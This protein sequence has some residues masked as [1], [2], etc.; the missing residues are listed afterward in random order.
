MSI[1]D[2]LTNL[3]ELS[4]TL[5]FE[6]VP[7]GKT[8]K[9][10][11]ANQVLVKDER[12]SRA[13]QDIKPILDQLHEEFI[14]GS[15]ANINIDWSGYLGI[16]QAV[17][18]EQDGEKKEVLR[19]KKIVIE[20][21][22]R[23][24]IVESYEEE[25]NKWKSEH[26][27]EK[28]KGLL[29]D[30]SYEVLTEEGILKVLAQKHKNDKKTIG[31]ISEFEGF[32]TY[33]SGFNNNRE[34][35]YSS[36]EK[37]T[38]IAN[39]IVN[40]NL[41][42]FCANVLSYKK[43]LLSNSSVKADKN[44]FELSHYNKVLTQ[45]DIEAYNY[46]IGEIN[47]RINLH[48]QSQQ[49]DKKIPLL[50]TLYKQIGCAAMK[51]FIIL[52]IDDKE[53][54]LE[55]AL[56]EYIK[57]ADNSNEKII[58]LINTLGNGTDINQVYLSS[59][60]IHA[61]SGKFFT[62]AGW[63]TLKNYL[64]DNKIYKRDK[65]GEAAIASYTKLSDL[66]KAI[67]AINEF[68]KNLFRDSF[69]LHFAS[70]TGFDIFLNILKD[71]YIKIY[72]IKQSKYFQSLGNDKHLNT[73]HWYLK[74][75]E[76]VLKLISRGLNKR[77][78]KQK[79]TIK[80]MA[81]DALTLFRMIKYFTVKE[82]R[83]DLIDTTFYEKLKEI[84]QNSLL[85]KY[86]DAIR[87][88]LTR[89]PYNRD[90]I[91]LN[92]ACST[93]LGGWDKNKETSNLSYILRDDSGKYFLAVANKNHNFCFDRQK[94]CYLYDISTNQ[95]V[96]Q[97]MEYKLLPGPNKMLPKV[98]FAKSNIKSPTNLKGYFDIPDAILRIREKESFKKGDTFSKTD[99]IKWIDFCKE[100]I[101]KYPDWQIFGFKFLPSNAYDDVSKFYNHIQKQ[102]Y[103]L[104]F[105]SINKAVI[106][107]MVEEGQIF[108]FQ[109]KNKDFNKK[110]E[111]NKPNLHTLY[112][113]NLFA[114]RS[115]L[116]KL[117]GEAELFYR[118]KSLE[119]TGEK[120][121][122]K[123]TCHE[124]IN[125][126]RYTKDKFLFH[127][128]IT[129][130]FCLRGGY[131][132]NRVREI[133]TKNSDVRMIG[134]DRGE[135]HLAYYSIINL[136]GNIIEQGTLNKDFLGQNYAEKL[137]KRAGDRDEARKNWQRIE[138]IKELKEGYIS[139]VV[140]R[141]A[142]LALEHNAIIILEDLNFR[143]MRGRQ[144]IEK[145]VYQKLELAL[146]KKLNYFVLK[147][148]KD[149]E[150][151]SVTKAYQL[152]PPTQNFGD[153]KGKQWGIMFYTRAAY[154]SI[155]DPV[156]GFRQNIYLKKGCR[157][158]MRS[159]IL[160]FKDIGFDNNKKA[161]YFRYNP[162]DFKD[163]KST[164]KEWTVW[165]NVERIINKKD[166]T[167]NHW[168]SENIDVN[169]NLQKIFSN[170]DHK[171]PLIEQ[172]RR[173]EDLPN[174]FYED[175][176]W[177]INRILQLRNSDSTNDDDYIQSP[178]EPFFDSREHKPKGQN[179]DGTDKANM[180]TCGDATGAYNIARKGLMILERIKE[181]SEK[182]DLHIKDIDWDKWTQAKN[183]LR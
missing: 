130:N 28:G 48:N 166:S 13:Y 173:K 50:S 18:Q 9:N 116:F 179:Q 121:S 6:L 65:E 150:I 161:Y 77:D 60:A 92:F 3:Y 147:D 23:N 182:A 117:N 85:S 115:N 105:M 82:D 41:P 136:R 91:K 52:E 29:K 27:D 30:K 133:I 12:K 58:A 145:S 151:G 181:D 40:E 106:E 162:V 169:K 34:N 113:H 70:G 32:F 53:L 36:D 94:N 86:Y 175:L 80:A 37:D 19:Q 35:Y 72:D 49:K 2:P 139:Q 101:N 183:K 148:K 172:I 39:R 51:K 76:E 21:D 14:K 96:W 88:Y 180:P 83:V 46:S 126:K 131:L 174:K 71:E 160:T 129:L 110:N 81:D 177:N 156:T 25:A 61:I 104:D 168:S 112:W 143:F 87:N 42:M 66:K 146:A 167:S 108:L 164:P 17:L 89:A 59:K 157:D 109:I 99:L 132:N 134:I 155:T 98:F 43:H 38:S 11:K 111:G 176:I 138:S 159:S 84:T 102:G 122:N 68:P 10:M 75:R 144:K 5:R 57:T 74:G 165:S 47:S 16:Y 137:H 141:I 20:K 125:K 135:K 69:E 152:T 93:L 15:L 90:K 119:A 73:S 22:L 1:W 107:K 149:D 4:K 158:S 31:L 120:R 79:E 123:P 153:I 140:K 33:F 55:K 170:F 154:T 64:V 128:P 97:K 44:I 171:L 178:V 8:L 54:T 127:V 163:N 62:A 24:K 95:P 78:E 56:Q 26:K 103:K 118:P 124:I 142:D 100:N 45:K 7:Q 67:E 114:D 63:F